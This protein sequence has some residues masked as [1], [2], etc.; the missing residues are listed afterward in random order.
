VLLDVGCR[1]GQKTLLFWRKVSAKKIIGIDGVKP[2]L[3]AARQRGIKDVVV[4]DLEKRWPF[5][6][7][8]FD[9]VVSNQVIEHVVDLD[10]FLGEVFRVL[11]PGGYRVVSTENLASWHNIF[12]LILGY[13]DF[14]HHLIRKSHVGNPM[15]PHFGEKTVSWSARDNSGVDDTRYPHVKIMTYRSLIKVFEAFG[16]KFERGLASGY[17]PFFGFVSRIFCGLDPYH[18]HFITVKFRK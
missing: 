8:Y 15:S 3:E 6:K 11:K 17:Y 14:S 16:F 10:H 2:R 7:N 9:V 12:S 18:S 1:D 13:Q 4:S 5:R